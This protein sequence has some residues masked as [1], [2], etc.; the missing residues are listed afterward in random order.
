VDETAVRDAEVEA[1]F[2]LGDESCLAEVYERWSPLVYSIAMRS[3]GDRTD[4]EDV[5]QQVFVSAWQGRER[6]SREAGTM[7][8]W[9]LGITRNKV[10]DRQQ[11]RERERRVADAMTAG[12]PRDHLAGRAGAEDS[13]ADRLL[14]VD[15]LARLG[16]Q[17]RRILELA[18]YEDLTHAQ[19]ADRLRLPLGTV[20]SHI[21]RSLERMRSHLEVDRV[22]L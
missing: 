9:L 10:A 16:D 5:T 12:T 22:A 14:V 19:I 13:V 17:Q 7:A 18:F 6:Y 2:A 4:A 21:R 20:K 8:G 11:A 1:R 15:A 3:L